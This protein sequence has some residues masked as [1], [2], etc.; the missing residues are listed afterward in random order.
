VNRLRAEHPCH[1]PNE[2]RLLHARALEGGGDAAA[3][4]EEYRGLVP[5]SVG[6]EARCRYGLAL[7][8]LGRADEA[9]AVFAEAAL[10]AGRTPSPVEAEQRWAKLAREGA[11]R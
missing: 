1:R 9:R 7:E 5:A 6:L 4:L 2:V 11:G 10:Q 8:R 3:A